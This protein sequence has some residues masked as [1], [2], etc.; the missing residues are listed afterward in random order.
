MTAPSIE[1][2]GR[3]AEW[4]EVFIKNIFVERACFGQFKFLDTVILLHHF[5]LSQHAV[6]ENLGAM[7]CN[8]CYIRRKALW[9]FNLASIQWKKYLRD[10]IVVAFT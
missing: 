5:Y 6:D 2:G 4:T 3:V 8:E 1:S 9:Y 7:A 10:K